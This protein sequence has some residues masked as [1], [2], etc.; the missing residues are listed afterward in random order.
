MH[1]KFWRLP[2]TSQTNGFS[3][4]IANGTQNLKFIR[5]KFA[6]R[7][8]CVSTFVALKE[9]SLFLGKRSTG[10][11]IACVMHLCAPSLFVLSNSIFVTSLRHCHDSC[12]CTIRTIQG[13]KYGINPWKEFFT[14]TATVVQKRVKSH[15]GQ[16]WFY[17]FQEFYPVKKE[18]TQLQNQHYQQQEEA[19]PGGHNQIFLSQ[20]STVFSLSLWPMRAFQQKT[21]NANLSR[22]FSAGGWDEHLS[23]AAPPNSSTTV[24]QLAVSKAVRS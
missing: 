2:A 24:P 8:V 7:F 17:M 11:Q 21:L 13:R 19:T 5:S 20:C 10:L 12:I 23:K 6:F 15:P 18:L 22:G 1:A 14:T 9:Q 16:Q 3:E 4:H